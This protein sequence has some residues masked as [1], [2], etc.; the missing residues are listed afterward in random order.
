MLFEHGVQILNC[1]G[2]GE[3]VIHAGGEDLSVFAL[4]GTRGHGNDWQAYMAGVEPQPARGILVLRS[5][6]IEPRPAGGGL[7]HLGN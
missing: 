7:I 2:F 1:S 5:I 6:G 3:D 4:H